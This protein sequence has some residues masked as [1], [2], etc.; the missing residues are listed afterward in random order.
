[1][2][3]L[4]WIFKENLGL[5]IMIVIGAVIAINLIFWKTNKKAFDAEK[6]K[7]HGR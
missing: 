2:E 7:R 4:N 1:M 5:W 6:N 3:I